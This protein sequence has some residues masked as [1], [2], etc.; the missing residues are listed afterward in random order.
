MSVVN[1]IAAAL[2]CAIAERGTAS[3]VVSGGLQP[4][5][6]FC[7]SRRWWHDADVDWA[8]VKIPLS[9]IARCQS[10]MMTATAN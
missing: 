6:Y 3:F 8:R 10:V 7:G 5:F 1:Q 9:M 4:N 2:A